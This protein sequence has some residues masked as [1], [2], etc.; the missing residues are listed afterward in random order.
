MSNEIKASLLGAA[1]TLAGGA[2]AFSLT[3]GASLAKIET[4]TDNLDTI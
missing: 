1:V 2:L 4:N 3:Y